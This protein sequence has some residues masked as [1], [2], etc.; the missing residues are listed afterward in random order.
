MNDA[1]DTYLP[2]DLVIENILTRLPIRIL[3]AQ[4]SRVSKLWCNS[5][6]INA[7]F[8]KTHFLHNNS[9]K[10]NLVFNLL[11]VWFAQGGAS[12]FSLDDHYKFRLLFDLES[13]NKIEPVGYCNGFACITKMRKNAYGPNLMTVINPIR[14]ET[15]SLP[16]YYYPTDDGE[17]EYLC[18]GFGFDSS[19]DEYKVVI[20]FTSKGN[21]ELISMAFTLGT[22]LWRKSVTSVAQIFPAQGC[23]AY[24]SRQ[25]VTRAATLCGG[26]L[27]WRITNS[28]VE[29]E[30]A[31]TY[32]HSHQLHDNK[33][34]GMLLSFDIHKEKIQFIRLPTEFN[35]T[36]MPNVVIQH[37]PLEHKGY[38]CVAQSE[39]TMTNITHCSCCCH[40][41]QSR[42]CCCCGRF[43]VQLYVLKDKEKQVW[44]KGETLGFQVRELGSLPAPFC[45]YFE[46]TTASTASFPMRILSVSDQV[47]LYWFDGKCLKLY[48]LQTKHLEVVGAHSSCNNQSDLIF[49]IKMSESPPV[50]GVDDDNKMYCPYLDYQL[51]ARAENILSLK[52]FISAGDTTRYNAHLQQDG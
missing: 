29:E 50:Q 24:L 7:R 33:K 48:N 2:E 27:F 21:E 8:A 3:D 22:N 6:S 35:L 51:H 30:T 5:I 38:P 26:D 36:P 13:D 19:T 46:T 37:H 4:Y 43:T 39:K 16:Y 47:L 15:L 12:F 17:C 10:L 28:A 32:K 9:H 52:A 40:N 34:F 31:I 49:K 1:A 45:C 41:E 25:L 23:S 18:H 42:I 14:E 20:I 11:N 44:I